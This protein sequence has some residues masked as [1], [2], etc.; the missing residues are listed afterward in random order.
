MAALYI[1]NCYLAFRESSRIRTLIQHF[2]NLVRHADDDNRSL[3]RLINAY[4]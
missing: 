2:D 1:G 4:S 3:N